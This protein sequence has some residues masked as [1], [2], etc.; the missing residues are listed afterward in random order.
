MILVTL[1]VT[2][3]WTWLKTPSWLS[4]ATCSV[5]PAYTNGSISIH[6]QRNALFAKP[7]S[8]KTDWFLST[9]EANH[10]PTLDPSPSRG[11]KCRAVPRDRDPKQRSLR[12]LTMVFLT[13]GLEDSWAG[14]QLRWRV[15]G[16]GTLR[17]LR[18]LA[19]WFLRCS[20]SISMGSLMQP[21]MELLL[22]RDSLTVSRTRSMEDTRICIVITGTRGGKDSK[23]TT[24]RHCLPLFSSSFCCPSS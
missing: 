14:L 5:G 11:S 10:L 6:S 8:R 2:S 20:T 24:W 23:I 17:C 16:L 12:S 21:C 4:V 9:A 13:T 3:A 15:R 18:R 19:V 7:S 1:N 22:L